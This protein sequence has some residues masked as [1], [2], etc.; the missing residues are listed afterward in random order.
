MAKRRDMNDP[1]YNPD[2]SDSDMSPGVSPSPPPKARYQTANPR[3]TG[4][5]AHLTNS[6]SNN[7]EFIDL[8]PKYTPPRRGCV[9]ADGNFDFL[10][11][12]VTKAPKPKDEDKPSKKRKR[13]DKKGN[14]KAKEERPEP[15]LNCTNSKET[16]QLSWI[17]R[18]E[19]MALQQPGG[20]IAAPVNGGE[21]SSRGA[22]MGEGGSVGGAESTGM[23]GTMDDGSMGGAGTLGGGPSDGLGN[24]GS[25]G[26]SAAGGSGDK[27][28]KKITK[29]LDRRGRTGPKRTYTWRDPVKK[30]KSGKRDGTGRG[31]NAKSKGKEM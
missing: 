29:P 23:G 11:H 15:A 12:F 26:G 16:A 18:A 8:V 4:I 17:K 27:K 1:F 24:M 30:N 25:V 21:G 22:A 28:P 31:K 14:D 5:M 9:P 10:M 3:N 20:G 2:L 19:A 13:G 7:G 6:T